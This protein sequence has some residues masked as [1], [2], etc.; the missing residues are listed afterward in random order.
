VSVE[1]AWY[2]P[3]YGTKTRTSVLVIGTVGTGSVEVMFVLET[4]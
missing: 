1:E 3:A 2:A 4:G